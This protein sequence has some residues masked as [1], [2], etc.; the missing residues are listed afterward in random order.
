MTHNPAVD[1][2]L[3]GFRDRAEPEIGLRERLHIETGS[4][5]LSAQ[6]CGVP[7]IEAHQPDIEDFSV[8]QDIV[9]NAVIVDTVA[10]CGAYPARFHPLA[11]DSAIFVGDVKQLRFRQIMAGQ[12]A[13]LPV[14]R[15]SV[16]HAGD[17][18]G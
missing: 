6:M 15:E 18:A 3:K 11:V 17:I 10:G 7:G 12:Q 9:T 8:A 2:Y 16:A 5:K 4:L 1:E 14:E 13:D